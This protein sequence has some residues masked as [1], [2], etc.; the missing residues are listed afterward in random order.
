MLRRNPGLD[1]TLEF[2]IPSRRVR[3]LHGLVGDINS[4]GVGGH[5]NSKVPTAWGLSTNSAIKPLLS[6]ESH[7]EMTENACA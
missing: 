5:M 1:I 6:V 4:Y 7:H 3:H 2:R